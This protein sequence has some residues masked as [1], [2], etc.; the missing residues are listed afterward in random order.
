MKPGTALTATAAAVLVA[1]TACSREPAADTAPPAPGVASVSGGEPPDRSPG[2]PRAAADAAGGG[3]A[4]KVAGP[5]PVLVQEL[6]WD[7]LVPANYRPDEIIAKYSLAP[8]TDNDPRAIK[9]YE[10]LRAALQAAPVVKELDGKMVRLPGYVVPLESDGQ[11]TSEFLLVPY[12]GA[13]IHVPPPPANQT[14]YVIAEGAGAQVKQLFDAVWVTGKLEVRR[15]RSELA[16][17]GYVLHASHV[18]RYRARS[19]N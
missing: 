18:E 8:L 5:T 3:A 14:I 13:C 10:E 12:V 1:L 19:R 4:L 6:K 16:D 9:L 7:D 11:R 15:A 2:R 17:A